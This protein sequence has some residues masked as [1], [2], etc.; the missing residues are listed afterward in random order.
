MFCTVCGKALRE[1]DAFCG[2]CG[3]RVESVAV[4]GGSAAEAADK[5][6]YPSRQAPS[7][8]PPQPAASGRSALLWVLAGVGLLLAAGL[9]VTL[10]L[11]LRGSKSEVGE[12]ERVMRDYARALERKDA[13]LLAEVME[14]DFRDELGKTV[15]R[16]WRKVIEDYIFTEIPDDLNINVK[17]TEVEIKGD[18]AT[19]LVL[20]GTMTYTDESGE[21]VTERAEDSD[22]QEME[23]V[24]VDGKW[25]LSGGWLRDNGYD[26][27]KLASLA[28]REREDR[29]G[30]RKSGGAVGAADAEAA[31][32]GYLD[33]GEAPGKGYKLIELVVSG[34]E[35]WGAAID[36]YGQ[37]S[38][39]NIIAAEHP[40]GW[41]VEEAGNDLDYPWWYQGEYLVLESA[42][43]DYVYANAVPGL[44]FQVTD[45]VIRGKEAAGIAMSTNAEMEQPLVLMRRGAGGWYGVDIGTGIEVPWWYGLYMD[46]KYGWQ[47]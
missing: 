10:I 23:M 16:D 40:G 32:L 26:P 37:G 27:E 36:L 14:P 18:R 44:T 7:F 8:P 5:P 30:D 31:M 19:L 1:G 20:E 3:T 17:S 2:S 35:A 21:K 43:L 38:S 45:L 39:I 33:S 12:V 28:E 34:G 25:Y 6:M 15:G 13:G 29:E 47:D 41:R 24:K 4:S 22:V 42:M 11:L 46:F 9:A